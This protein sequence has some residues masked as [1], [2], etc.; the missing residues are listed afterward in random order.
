V[1]EDEVTIGHL[2]E[3]QNDFERYLDD[4]VIAIKESFFDEE[5]EDEEDEDDDEDD[6]ETEKDKE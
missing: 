6:E 3:I 5:D 1:K 4:T 2:E